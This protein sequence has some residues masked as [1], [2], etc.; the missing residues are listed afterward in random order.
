VDPK[1]VISEKGGWGWIG[2]PSHETAKFTVYLPTQ[3]TVKNIKIEWK[4]RP[5]FYEV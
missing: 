5:L 2:N 3:I 1:S 4:I